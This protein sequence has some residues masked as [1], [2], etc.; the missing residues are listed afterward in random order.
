M[1]PFSRITAFF[2]QPATRHCPGAEYDE[3]QRYANEVADLRQEFL[4]LQREAI[5]H[6][7]RLNANNK[8]LEEAEMK[9]EKS[10]NYCKFLNL[11]LES[12][13]RELARLQKTATASLKAVNAAKKFQVSAEERYR[14]Q[15][16]ILNKRTA[17]L[18]EAADEN[19]SLAF[20]QMI[21]TKWTDSF[22]D[23]EINQVMGSLNQELETWV[24]HHFYRYTSHGDTFHCVYGL[25]IDQIFH[26]ILSR[27]MVGT[28]ADLHRDIF[29]DY[30]VSLDIEVQKKCP[31][32]VAQHWRSALSKAAFSFGKERLEA[33]CCGLVNHVQTRCGHLSP[34]NPQKRSE[35][36]RSLIWKFVEFK[37]RLECQ[38]NLYVFLMAFPNTRFVGDQMVSSTGDYG[39]STLVEY[40]LAPALFKIPSGSAGGSTTLVVKAIVKTCP[41]F[42]GMILNG[43]GASGDDETDSSSL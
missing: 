31:S 8:K 21:L 1:P 12:K 11:Q 4:K 33:G 3:V 2:S 32:H 35:E 13:D 22:G 23:D 18:E 28:A 17:E 10:V 38:A 25:V 20:Q 29:S 41:A 34:T 27:A 40:T 19:S 7:W 26:A 16:E 30:F 24:K 9:L 39:A 43:A 15:T 5:A 37:A 36:L 14:R 42:Q 6:K